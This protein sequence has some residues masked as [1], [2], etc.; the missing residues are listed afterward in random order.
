MSIEKFLGKVIVGDCRKVLKEFP[1]ESVNFVMTGPMYWG[2]KPSPELELVEGYIGGEESLD[3]YLN[4]LVEVFMEVYRVLCRDGHLFIVIDDHRDKGDWQMIPE[5]LALLLRE[6]GWILR[7]KIIWHKLDHLPSPYRYGFT[8]AY[9]HILH[10]VKT[11]RPY[12]A[13]D[14][15]RVPH[16]SGMPSR[17]RKSH[18]K[19]RKV[20]VH[21]GLELKA[22]HTLGKNP[23][24]VWGFAK[25]RTSIP[26]FAVFPESICERVIKFGCPPGGIVL[27]PFC[28]TGTTLV[29]AKRLGRRWI[30]IEIYEEYAKIARERVSKEPVLWGWFE[31]VE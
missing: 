11:L 22:Y 27:D 8:H 1:D 4:S 3:E 13:L 28:G 18:P 26:H 9:E 2:N 17:G 29:V 16:E 6:E 12:S 19:H 31:D 20:G 15:V 7:D 10:F 14:E 25:A 21:T 24:D 30:G 23:G 5:Q